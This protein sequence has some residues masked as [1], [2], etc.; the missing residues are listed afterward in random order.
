MEFEQFVIALGTAQTKPH[1]TTV[2]TSVAVF[3]HWPVQSTRGGLHCCCCAIL[4]VASQLLDWEDRILH[5]L[6]CSR[7]RLRTE[8]LCQFKLQVALWPDVSHCSPHVEQTIPS[9]QVACWHVFVQKSVSL[10]LPSSHCS[11]AWRHRFRR[12]MG[13]SVVQV[14]E[15]P[16]LDCTSHRHTVTCCGV[17]DSVAAGDISWAIQFA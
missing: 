12:L 8:Q 16:S 6:R 10:L 9:P 4:Q 11:P 14:E 5:L 15:Q 1:P 3:T 2:L 13:L 7:S 17:H